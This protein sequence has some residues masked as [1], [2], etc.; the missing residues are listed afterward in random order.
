LGSKV[1]LDGV[2]RR[3]VIQLVK[4]RLSGK[5]ELEP[6]EVVEREYTMQEIVDASEEGRLVECFA[7]GT[8][9]SFYPT[10]G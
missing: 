10:P 8:A 9:V 1:I 7:C 4:E 2:T 5:G 6:I 3:S